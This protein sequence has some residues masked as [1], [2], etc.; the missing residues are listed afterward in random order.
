MVLSNLQVSIMN[1]IVSIKNSS[2]ANASFLV[3]KHDLQIYNSRF[4]YSSFQGTGKILIQDSTFSNNG[5]FFAPYGYG[6]TIKRCTFD[7][8]PVKLTGAGLIFDTVFKNIRKA[9]MI[10]PLQF[11]AQPKP[12]Y[13][14]TRISR[15]KFLNNFLKEVVPTIIFHHTQMVI[16]LVDTEVIV[17]AK[18]TLIFLA[19]KQID[20]MHNFSVRCAPGYL[21]RYYPAQ[22]HQSALRHTWL[23]CVS[24]G[25]GRYNL[26]G[27]HYVWKNKFSLPERDGNK[28]CSLCPVNGICE[29]G[30]LRSRGSY[31]GYKQPGGNSIDFLPCPKYYCC[32]AVEHCDSY[33]TCSNNRRGRLCSECKHGYS[34]SVNGNYKC[35]HNSKC[36]NASVGFTVISLL[37]ILFLF[38]LL[39]LKEILLFLK[40]LI[41]LNNK[42]DIEY[43]QEEDSYALNERLIHMPA[44]INNGPVSYQVLPT[45]SSTEMREDDY[46]KTSSTM[47]GLLKILFF[48]YQAA[49]IVRVQSP[50][51]L[52]VKFPKFF[53]VL[54]T[55]F[56]VRID[57]SYSKSNLCILPNLSVINAE[58]LKLTVIWI[59]LLVLILIW[60][61]AYLYRKIIERNNT[62]HEE[63]SQRNTYTVI[64]NTVPSYCSMPMLTRVKCTYLQ[65]LLISFSSVATFSFN[66]VY[67]VQINNKRYL[68][69]QASI[70][71]YQ[72]WQ[73][74]LIAF[75]VFWIVPFCLSLFLMAKLLYQCK[76]TPNQFLASLTFPPLMF[77]ILIKSRLYTEGKLSE[78]DAVTG[79]HLLLVINEPFRESTGGNG[80]KICW[81]SVL[82][83][84]RMVLVMMKTFIMSP[85][86]KLYPM[87]VLLFLFRYQHVVTQ[88]FSSP[89]LNKVEFVSMNILGTFVVVNIFWAV[90]REYNLVASHKI[91]AQLLIV[92]EMVILGLPFLLLVFYVIVYCIKK[93]PGLWIILKNKMCYRK[94]D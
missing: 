31:W 69:Q 42:N 30:I 52:N 83:S 39:Y 16:H 75:I 9:K 84:R 89:I 15:C 85:I 93:I 55:V 32:P 57:L 80:S 38:V 60:I 40:R 34:C 37:A 56:S 66:A 8:S 5:V 92:Y 13:D 71:C 46:S 74:F 41:P 12:N 3:T 22:R 65:L 27:D 10:S 36:N 51:K 68:Y 14:I 62:T 91:L 86:D 81:E 20:Q 78:K 87:A 25:K 88:P 19:D 54:I 63:L 59:M 47:S 2:V 45:S 79:K 35:V 58:V 43:H 48:F 90:S 94:Q 49:S 6:F 7:N 77:P 24:C 53:D 21:V 23:N 73:Y 26:N 4:D 70:E 1:N 72:P 82:I 64:N 28:I 61:L 33:D 44:H 76:I 67:C 11:L 29:S 50:E 18:N 17:P